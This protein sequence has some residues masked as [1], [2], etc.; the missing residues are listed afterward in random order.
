M[1]VLF[2]VLLAVL[3]ACSSG[4]TDKTPQ[5]KPLIEAVYASGF[6]VSK[7][8]YQVFAQA[9]GYLV[10]IVADEGTIVKK[11]D[12]LF[13]LESQQQTSRYRL[14]KESYEMARDN[15][16]SGSP[17]LSELEASIRSA[18][19]KVKF[20]SINVE[21]YASLLKQNATTR[22]DFDRMKLA[23]ENSTNDLALMRSRYNKMRNQLF[24]DLKSAES[25]LQ[26]AGEES[27]RYIVRSEIN[28]RVYKKLKEKGELVRRS[29]AVAVLGSSDSFYLQLTVDEMDVRK[30][31]SGQEVLAKIDAFGDQTFKATVTQVH[32]LV[33]SREQ[34][35]RV[36]ADFEE[37]LPHTFS[38]LAVEAN[39]IIQRK[40][41]ALVIPKSVLLP[42]DSVLIQTGQGDQ[43]VKIR[44]GIETLDEVEVLEGLSAE[45]V[46]LVKK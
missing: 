22:A 6:V 33:D 7:N 18:E 16:Q 41:H 38:G 29:E 39:I 24:L 46:L 26:I 20:D 17:V 30:V 44:K 28:G 35:I 3:V 5:V 8:E 19:A 14:A 34:S 1:K 37:P 36:D 31:K 15:Y 9:E 10:E 13:V 12:P 25:Q 21:R 27:G 23:F 43:K 40:E 4:N 45:N 2:P 42:G 32:Q 11:G